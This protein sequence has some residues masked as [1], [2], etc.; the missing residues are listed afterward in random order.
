MSL[1]VKIYRIIILLI[2]AT[3]SA[4]LTWSVVRQIDQL[5]VRFFSQYNDYIGII[6]TVIAL[7]GFL[8]CYAQIYALRN[9]KKNILADPEVLDNMETESGNKFWYGNLPYAISLYIFT[10]YGIYQTSKR[11]STTEITGDLIIISLIIYGAILIHLSVR[12]KQ[13]LN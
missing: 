5:G 10:I 2:S 9:S 4:L 13:R 3:F 8:S 6:V 7:T 1:G 12:D 11:P